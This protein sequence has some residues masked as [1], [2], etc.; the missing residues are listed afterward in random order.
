MR[1]YTALNLSQCYD[2]VR[3]RLDLER[4]LEDRDP[5]G[6]VGRVTFDDT[7]YKQIKT[8]AKAKL[9]AAGVAEAAAVAAAGGIKWSTK[10]VPVGRALVSSH[11]LRRAIPFHSSSYTPLTPLTPLTRLLHA[12]YTPLARLFHE[13]ASSHHLGVLFLSPPPLFSLEEYTF[14]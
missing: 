10:E 4:E 8:S 12:S 6:K 11:H 3:H 7:S 13:P 9:S 14:F 1:T 5:P 2:S